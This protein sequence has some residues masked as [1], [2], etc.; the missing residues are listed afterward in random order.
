[1]CRR[2]PLS[3]KSGSFKNIPFYRKEKENISF[4]SRESLKTKATDEEAKQDLWEAK[5]RHKLSRVLWL[6]FFSLSCLSPFCDCTTKKVRP[7]T[8]VKREI[9]DSRRASEERRRETLSCACCPIFHNLILA[10]FFL[11]RLTAFGQWMGSLQK[12]IRWQSGFGSFGADCCCWWWCCWPS[13]FRCKVL[14]PIDYVGS[15]PMCNVVWWFV[16]RCKAAAGVVC[17]IWDCAR[18]TNLWNFNDDPVEYEMNVRSVANRLLLR[19]ITPQSLPN[20]K[21]S[22]RFE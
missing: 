22:S 9:N 21:A 17:G 20:V 6:P 11:P 3:L 12:S 10:H 5:V 13:H 15:F 19:C 18:S 2:S 14:M 8:K 1:M 4:L 7:K 16:T